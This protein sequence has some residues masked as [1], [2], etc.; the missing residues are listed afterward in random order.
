MLCR[1]SQP[2]LP[3]ILKVHKI[4]QVSLQ[5]K[6]A[7]QYKVNKLKKMLLHVLLSYNEETKQV[8]KKQP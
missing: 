8:K 2:G 3:S 5:E 4:G 6:E 1:T 7:H